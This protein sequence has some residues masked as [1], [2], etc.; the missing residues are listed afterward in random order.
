MIFTIN[1]F[2]VIKNKL[3]ED[4]CRDDR[5]R[6][7][8]KNMSEVTTVTDTFYTKAKCDKFSLNNNK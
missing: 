2:N 1:T 3:H 7:R 4:C 6:S 5:L 8:R